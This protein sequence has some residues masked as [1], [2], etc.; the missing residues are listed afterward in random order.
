MYLSSIMVLIIAYFIGSVP[1]A[2]ILGKILKGRDYDIRDH[3]SGNVGTTNV[4]R[5][6]GWPA[7]LTTFIFD[8][9][10]GF[11]VLYWMPP[12]I[13]G[14]F[15]LETARIVLG[16]LVLI[17]H[18]FPVYIGFRGGK[19]VATTAGIIFAFSWQ[20][21]LICMAAFILILLL[22]RQSGVASMGAAFFFPL[23]TIFFHFFT[24][25]S[26][27]LQMLC[28]SIAIPFYILFTHRENIRKIQTGKN[29]KDF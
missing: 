10:K 22:S 8:S 14:L 7:G 12:L 21:G 16:I 20:I 18:T 13:T 17:G 9:F 4:I 27:S 25:M 2:W 29:K 11:A 3:G 15:S 1:T 28:F 19:A 23:S 5:N 26:I 24:E 6:L